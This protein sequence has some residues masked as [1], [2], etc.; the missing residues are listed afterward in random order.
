MRSRFTSRHL[1]DHRPSSS[2]LTRSIHSRWGRSLSLLWTLSAVTSHSQASSASQS[3]NP[4]SPFFLFLS[5]LTHLILEL[6]S[7]VHFLHINLLTVIRKL[8]NLWLRVLF[9]ISLGFYDTSVHS[10]LSFDFSFIRRL[11]VLSRDFLWIFRFRL[12]FTIS[13]GVDLL[14]LIRYLVFFCFSSQK[15]SFMSLEAEA[16]SSISFISFD[17]IFKSSHT[18][19]NWSS[20]KNRSTNHPNE[21]VTSDTSE[22]QL[23][24]NISFFINV[25]T[26]EVPGFVD[27]TDTTSLQSHNRRSQW[28]RCQKSFAPSTDAE[29]ITDSR[30]ILETTWHDDVIIMSFK[31][32]FK[33]SSTEKSKSKSVEHKTALLY[34]FSRLWD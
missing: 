20:Q 29:M 19:R 25:I 21:I 28:Y 26:W 17:A 33:L 14:Q 22:M 31:C 32:F 10:W 5:T 23:L 16:I 3:C 2:S 8:R 15:T 27:L 7:T 13:S 1:T 18:N 24:Y 34:L 11:L 6:D 30:R 12:P 9:L 4:F